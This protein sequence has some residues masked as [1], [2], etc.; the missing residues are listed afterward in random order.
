MPLLGES[1]E[2]AKMLLC[3][4][5]AVEYVHFLGP[6]TV[7][8]AIRDALA[9]LSSEG[10]YVPQVGYDDGLSDGEI[11]SSDLDG[12]PDDDDGGYGPLWPF[13]DLGSSDFEGLFDGD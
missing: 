12:E 10:L 5:S 8:R 1:F 7:V 9:C 6:P 11:E 3:G 13:G 4:L 2:G